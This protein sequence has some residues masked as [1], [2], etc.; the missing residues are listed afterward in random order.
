MSQTKK[1]N[2][3][4]NECNLLFI[5]LMIYIPHYIFDTQSTGQKRIFEVN[6]QEKKV[7]YLN[8]SKLLFLKLK[9]HSIFNPRGKKGYLA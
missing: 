6:F 7:M 4:S 9:I 8:K 1:K 5:K 3:Y 2:M